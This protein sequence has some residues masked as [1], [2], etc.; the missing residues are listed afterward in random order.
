METTTISEDWEDAW[1]PYATAD[2]LW[3]DDPPPAAPS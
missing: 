3:D 1:A 2:W